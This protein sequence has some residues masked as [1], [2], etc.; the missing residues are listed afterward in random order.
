[1]GLFQGFI[2]VEHT[3]Q[4]R[5][6]SEQEGSDC[7]RTSR[8]G[9]DVSPRVPPARYL[10]CSLRLERCFAVL[11]TCSKNLGSIITEPRMFMCHS[12]N[13]IRPRSQTDV[14]CASA[15][16]SAKLH[17]RRTTGAQSFTA[18]SRM[19]TQ[20]ALGGEAGASCAPAGR[21]GPANY[22]VLVIVLVSVRVV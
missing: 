4:I 13:R 12:A 16:T 7:P 18:A 9:W 1:M 8:A 11:Q 22:A 20:P 6:K 19:G 5:S 10:S 15:R 21:Q 3:S 2:A 17:R 14:A